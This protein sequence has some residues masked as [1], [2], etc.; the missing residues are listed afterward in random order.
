MTN[1]YMNVYC[2]APKS[3]PAFPFFVLCLHM[4]FNSS[5]L[6]MSNFKITR[7]KG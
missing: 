6:F 7:E 4:V 1:K 3:S 2:I 5:S